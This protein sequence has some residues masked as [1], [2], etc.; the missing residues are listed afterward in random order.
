MKRPAAVKELIA[1]LKRLPGIGQ[2][3]AERRSFDLMRGDK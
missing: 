1:E 3:T 2:K